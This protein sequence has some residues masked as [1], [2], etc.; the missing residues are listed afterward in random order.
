MFQDLRV[1]IACMALLGNIKLITEKHV[2]P[3]KFFQFPL[4]LLQSY[5]LAF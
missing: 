5:T 4:S 1:L 3:F 2:F